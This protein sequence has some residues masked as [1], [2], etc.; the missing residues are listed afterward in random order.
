MDC[1][2][3]AFIRALPTGSI[4]FGCL[5]FVLFWCE[6][7]LENNIYILGAALY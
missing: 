3:T 7:L 5:L 4:S 6:H 2:N 1:T